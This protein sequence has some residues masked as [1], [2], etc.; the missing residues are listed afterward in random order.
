MYP[1]EVVSIFRTYVVTLSLAYLLR[2]SEGRRRKV[3]KFF[4]RPTKLFGFLS[5]PN[6]P[7]SGPVARL[8]FLTV[9]FDRK[10]R[11][12][13]SFQSCYCYY[14]NCWRDLAIRQRRLGRC[15][16]NVENAVSFKRHQ[17][18]RRKLKKYSYSGNSSSFHFPYARSLLLLRVEL[19]KGQLIKKFD[20]RG[21]AKYKK[22]RAREISSKKYSRTQRTNTQTTFSTIFNNLSYLQKKIRAEDLIRKNKNP[23]QPVNAKTNSCEFKSPPPRLT[24]VND[25]SLN[26]IVVI[27]Y[28]LC[29]HRY[30]RYM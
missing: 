12:I 23:A 17:L 16:H 14:N 5:R 24:F 18:A 22:N 26:T 15:P 7:S 3:N 29:R 27:P 8:G 13:R 20:R 4:S 9:V 30:H 11:L 10:V 2:L 21:W 28:S 6:P 1:L 19:N 25:S